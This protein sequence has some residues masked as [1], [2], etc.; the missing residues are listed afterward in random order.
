MVNSRYFLLVILSR[1][2][3]RCRFL[4]GNRGFRRRDG[5]KTIVSV[6]WCLMFSIWLLVA[7]C[8]CALG[9]LLV[10]VLLVY[11]GNLF[12]INDDVIQRCATT[13]GKFVTLEAQA[14]AI[15]DV[16]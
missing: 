2:R 12:L 1:D 8:W 13:V 7:G 15:E 16:Q 3:V 4:S 11:V 14:V 5:V 9:F 10:L 6:F